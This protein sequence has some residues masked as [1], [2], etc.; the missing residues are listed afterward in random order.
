MD[1]V[2][3][4]YAIS[5]KLHLQAFVPQPDLVTPDWQPQ[6]WQGV[7]YWFNLLCLL[8]NVQVIRA[9]NVLRCVEAMMHSRSGSNLEAVC[10]DFEVCQFSEHSF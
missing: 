9:F 2:Q 4:H 3:V 1:Q 8:T 10:L 7:D 5:F 6:S